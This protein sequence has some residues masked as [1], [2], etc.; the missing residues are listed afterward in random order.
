MTTAL[1]VLMVE[2][3]ATDAKLVVGE[4]RRAGQLV[5]FERVETVE[6]MRAALQREWDIV[7]SD[8]SMPKFTAP[9]ALAVL[10][11][12]GLDLPFI[13]VSGTIGEEAAVEAMR[14]GAHDYVLKDKLGRLMPAIER[15]VRECE[16]AR[17]PPTGGGSSTGERGAV[18]EA[19]RIR[20]HRYR[21][22]GCPRPSLRGERRLSGNGRLLARGDAAG[23][24]ALGRADA[25]RV[26]SSGRAVCRAAANNRGRP[27]LGNRNVSQGREPRSGPGRRGD[28][29]L[30]QDHRV[31]R[32]SDRTQASRG[33]TAA[34][35]RRSSSERGAAP[36][37][38]EDGGRRPTGRRRGARLQQRALGHPELRGLHS[39][40]PEAF[41]SA[42]SA[43][44]TRS[45]RPRSGRPGSPGSS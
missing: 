36:A 5:E 29:G 11:E 7:T 18:S 40:G 2:D 10:K 19:L 37:G 8:W 26:S 24:R 42:A 20:S 13:I 14:A 4:L 44:W 45:A 3:S 17:G 35:R 15:E 28:A 16:R 43:T 21:D 41:G 9:A 30:S 32:R 39:D 1:R 33:W 25:G 34:R 12:S 6:A 27:S 38:P 23:R 22:R 31:H